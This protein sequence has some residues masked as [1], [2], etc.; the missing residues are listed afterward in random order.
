MERLKVL[1]AAAAL[2][3]FT[4]ADLVRHTGV[5]SNTVSSVLRR[6]ARLFE[7]AKP[8]ERGSRGRGRPRRRY[9]V[10]DLTAINAEIRAIEETVGTVSRLLGVPDT[11]DGGGNPE[12]ERAALVSVAERTIMRAW[13]TDDA[14][15][16]RVLADTARLNL[17]AVAPS[18]APDMPIYRET[19]PYLRVKAPDE[20]GAPSLAGEELTVRARSLAVLVDLTSDAAEGRAI[21]VTDLQ[22]AATAVATLS[23]VTSPERMHRF[24][25][26]LVMIAQAGDE[27]APV[28]LVTRKGDTP[29]AVIEG[30]DD[31]E[32][33]MRK[34]PGTG[35]VVWAQRWARTLAD[36]RLYACNVLYDTGDRDEDFRDTLHRVA[37]LSSLSKPSVPR[38]VVSGSYEPGRINTVARAGAML[39]APD[40]ST[41]DLNS[42]I[43][44]GFELPELYTEP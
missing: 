8:S 21:G 4:V 20:R 35:D 12:E 3:T 13:D 2:H 36:R 40:F 27:L 15:D 30:V 25:G 7:D 32:W 19:S 11:E 31:S 24:L 9:A 17:A 39:L 1:A 37:D 41:D 14:D 42:A 28:G 10:A 33:Y 22:R 29:G 26:G 18:P 5:P 38:I 44:A 43:G 23:G 16:R 34:L 6:N